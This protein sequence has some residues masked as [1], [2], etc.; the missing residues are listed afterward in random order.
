MLFRVNIHKHYNQSNYIH[1]KGIYNGIT[2]L[3]PSRFKFIVVCSKTNSESKLDGLYWLSEHH[4][5][6]KN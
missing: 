4:N 3:Q 6:S 1:A 5:Q 2:S